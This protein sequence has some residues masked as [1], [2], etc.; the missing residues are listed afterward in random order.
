METSRAAF[1]Q[2]PCPHGLMEISPRIQGSN[3]LPE[4]PQIQKNGNIQ[5]Y[6]SC[7]DDRAQQPFNVVVHPNFRRWQLQLAGPAQI[8]KLNPLS[9]SV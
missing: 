7:H 8:W 3:P 5:K 6:Q 4:V 1:W 9:F 2:L